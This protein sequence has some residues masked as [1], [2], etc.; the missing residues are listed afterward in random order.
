M[1]CAAQETDAVGIMLVGASKSILVLEFEPAGRLAPF[2]GGVG[3]RA[4][5]SIPLVHE[6]FDCVGN[7]PGSR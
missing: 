1:M 6:A 7:V 2:A 5:A 3:K 4:P